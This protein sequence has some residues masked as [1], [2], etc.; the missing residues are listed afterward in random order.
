MLLQ[1]H[2]DHRLLPDQSQPPPEEEAGSAAGLAE[3]G[4]VVSH[5]LFDLERHVSL[6]N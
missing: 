1:Q 3:E 2:S 6:S 5:L 4:E